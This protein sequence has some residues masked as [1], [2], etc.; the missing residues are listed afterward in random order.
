MESI[1]E[2]TDDELDPAVL[3]QIGVYACWRNDCRHG[4]EI[5]PKNDAQELFIQ[6]MKR[7]C[8]RI[9]VGVDLGRDGYYAKPLLVTCRD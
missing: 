1:T 9:Y 3:E 2:D 8:S 5:V 6:S 7:K 4:N